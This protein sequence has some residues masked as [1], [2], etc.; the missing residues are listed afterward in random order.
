MGMKYTRQLLTIVSRLIQH[1]HKIAPSLEGRLIFLGLWPIWVLG[2]SC[3]FF[4]QKNVHIYTNTEFYRPWRRFTDWAIPH[5]GS[6]WS[7]KCIFK[8]TLLGTSLVAQWLRTRLP[9][10]GT[11]VR[12]L[13]REDPTCRGASKP[14]PQL[15]SLPSRACKPQLL[16]LCSRA[17][18]PQLLSPRAT[19]YWSPRA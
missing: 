8:I 17:H 1:K 16:S 4:I 6:L 15:L 18:E 19:N 11:Q 12:A 13:V 2:D 3:G 7:W 10:Q 9:M 14:M 5:R